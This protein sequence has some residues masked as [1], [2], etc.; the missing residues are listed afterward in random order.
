MNQSSLKKLEKSPWDW[1]NSVLY[2][3][4]RSN[5]DHKSTTKALGKIWIIGRSYSAA[6]ERGAGKHREESIDFYAEKVAP[7]LVN[8][9]I[10]KWIRKLNKIERITNENVDALLEIHSSFVEEIESITDKKKRSLASKYLHFHAP[11][12]VFI[13]DSIANREIRSILSERQSQFAYKKGY[14]D[15]Y[16]Q[17]VARCL[18][19][20]DKVI[21]PKLGKKVSPRFLDKVLLSSASGQL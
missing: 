8:S 10:D 5:P 1:G 13:Y 21:E 3:M 19:L 15:T 18:Y 16:S 20:R 12:A 14:D 6:I 11:N 7:M 17:F 2:D 4:C 9:D